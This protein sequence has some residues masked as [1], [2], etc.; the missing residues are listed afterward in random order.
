MLTKSKVIHT[1]GTR[2]RAVARLTLK[3]GKGMVRVNG[4]MLD[5]VEPKLARMKIQEPLLLVPDIASKIHIN[6]NVYG[7]GVMSQAEA[8]RQALGK[9]LSEFGGEKVRKLL[10]Q[11]DRA[12]LVADTRYKEPRKPNDSKA[13]AKRQKSYR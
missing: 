6:I 10:L 13:R 7:G 4:R 9:A 3:A 2:K 8:I 1:A 11:Y 5:A 12:F